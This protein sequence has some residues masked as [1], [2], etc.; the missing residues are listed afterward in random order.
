MFVEEGFWQGVCVGALQL[1]FS[2]TEVENPPIRL[3]LGFTLLIAH[4]IQ[5]EGRRTL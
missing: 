5:R 3:G 2:N 4:G 1:R